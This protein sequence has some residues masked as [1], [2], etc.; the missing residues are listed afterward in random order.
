MEDIF[1]NSR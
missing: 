1:E